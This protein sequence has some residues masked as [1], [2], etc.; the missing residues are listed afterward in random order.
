MLE[1]STPP[2]TLKLE[3]DPE[4]SSNSNNAQNKPNCCTY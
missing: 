2:T 3:I 1:S 4:V